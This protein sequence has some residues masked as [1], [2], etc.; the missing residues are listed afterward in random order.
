M[1]RRAFLPSAAA[2]TSLSTLRIARGAD[3]KVPRSGVT[4][5]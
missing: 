1:R 3:V 4:K 2:A 5:S